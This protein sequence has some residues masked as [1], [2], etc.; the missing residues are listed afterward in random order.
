MADRVDKTFGI[1]FKNGKF[2]IGNKIIKIQDDNIVIDNEVYI[3][4]PG[5]HRDTGFVDFNHRKEYNDEDY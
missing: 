1:R 3:G 4:T 5:L 2:M